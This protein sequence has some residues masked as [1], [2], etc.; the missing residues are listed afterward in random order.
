LIMPNERYWLKNNTGVGGLAEIT[1]WIEYDDFG[2][3]PAPEIVNR[4]FNGRLT[5]DGSNAI[6]TSGIT[7]G[8]I[9][10]VLPSNGDQISLYTP[11]SVWNTIRFTSASLGLTGL[12]P[13]SVYDIWGYKNVS[14]ITLE[15]TRWNVN[16]T[17]RTAGLSA[18]DGVWTQASNRTRVLLGTIY[19]G[20]T[21]GMSADSS[22]SRFLYNVYNQA[23][24]S[25]SLADYAPH[26]YNLN[27][28]RAYNNSTANRVQAVLGLAAPVTMG[29]LFEG[30]AATAGN[31]PIVQIGTD[32]TTVNDGTWGYF[33]STGTEA[34]TAQFIATQNISPGFHF[35]QTL[36]L[37]AIG[38]SGTFSTAVLQ[39]WLM[40]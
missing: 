18:Q 14:E 15:T 36:E 20:G 33:L 19:M 7:S 34:I 38:G 8:S 16:N 29:V 4:V 2:G 27:V 1:K 25:L 32:S 9:V 6:S 39:G 11:A 31:Y 24:R 26:T 40:A 10:Y 22:A 35:F 30:R 13:N 3:A 21:C 17:I 5:L 23:Q 28:Y 37:F 12:S